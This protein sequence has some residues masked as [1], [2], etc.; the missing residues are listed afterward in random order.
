M[1]S[2]AL[3]ECPWS[4]VVPGLKVLNTEKVQVCSHRFTLARDITSL[5]EAVLGPGE[6]TEEELQAASLHS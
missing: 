3:P 4:C 5:L 6:A 2:L 1:R